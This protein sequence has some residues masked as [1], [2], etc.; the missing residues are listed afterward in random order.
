MV[1]KFLRIALG[2][3]LALVATTTA[4]QAQ[5]FYL[6]PKCGKV[7]P[8]QTAVRAVQ[9]A[10]SSRIVNRNQAA[11]DHALR[12][13]HILA[14]RGFSHHPL[15]VAPGAR[16]AGTGSSFSPDSPNHCYDHWPESRLIARAVVKDSRG[17]YW[18]SAH[19]R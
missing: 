3:C 4:A 1:E 7:H 12:E 13:A 6:C 5:S 14:R 17:R 15:G 2:L 18:W 10:V 19:Y 16:Y 11:F 9:S 8:V